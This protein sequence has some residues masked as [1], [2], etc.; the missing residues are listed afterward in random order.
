[1][2]VLHNTKI[3][4]CI[5]SAMHKWIGVDMLFPICPQGITC[6]SRWNEID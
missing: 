5:C 1:M 3:I 2:N 4:Q 6:W